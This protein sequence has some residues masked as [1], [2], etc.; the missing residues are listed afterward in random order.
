MTPP[1]PR[2]PQASPP[3]I[4][5][6]PAPTGT[7]TPPSLLDYILTQ[8]AVGVMQQALDLL[9]KACHRCPIDDTMVGRHG[10]CHHIADNWLAVNWYELLARRRHSQDRGLRRV[11]A[12]GK[13]SGRPSAKVSDP[14]VEP[15]YIR[16]R[17]LR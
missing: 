6:S 17:G 5:T 11:R 8:Q 2:A 16:L 13:G 10:H 15:P 1:P 4:H 9:E 7:P 12:R 14:E 3:H